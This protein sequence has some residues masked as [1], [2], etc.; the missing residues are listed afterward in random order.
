MDYCAEVLATLAL[1]PHL[2]HDLYHVSAGEG[3]SCTF[4]DIDI[5]LAEGLGLEPVG[6]RFRKVTTEELNQLAHEFESRIGPCNRRLVLRALRLYAGFAK[7]NYVF[8]NSFLLAEGLPPVPRFTSY[9][10]LCAQTTAHIPVPDQM[11]WDF[12]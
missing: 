11:Q 5:A 1:K 9:I 8:D 3:A 2:A 12:K 4:A 6:S 7:L 10:G